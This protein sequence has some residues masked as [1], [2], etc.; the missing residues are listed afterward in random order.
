MEPLQLENK[1]SHVFEYNMNDLKTK[2]F[3]SWN[4]TCTTGQ[5]DNQVLE[6]NLYD[7]K[8]KIVKIVEYR[9]GDW[10]P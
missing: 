6:Y 4:T 3:K 9:M 7:W 10:K 2:I 5:K 8:T 1:D